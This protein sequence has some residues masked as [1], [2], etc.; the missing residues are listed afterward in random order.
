MSEVNNSVNAQSASSAPEAAPQEAQ[1]QEQNLNAPKTE[2]KAEAAKQEAKKLK[3]VKYKANG[4][5]YSEDLPFEI[6]DNPAAI[7]Y[8]TKQLSLS[9]AAQSAM[10]ES[11]SVKKQVKDF[12]EYLGK[13]TRKAL[14]EMGI[15]VRDLAAAVIEEEIKAAQ[16]TPEQKELE[17]LRSQKKMMEE[18]KQRLREE[19]EAASRSAEEQKAYVEIEKQI[20]DAI[21][22]THL[23][24]EPA[25]VKRV[26][27]Y[28][29]IAN[30]RGIELS[31]KDAMQF[32]EQDVRDEMKS[33]IDKLDDSAF[34]D[35]VGKERLSRQ[36]KKNIAK[37]K[38]VPTTPAT[39]KGSTVEVKKEAKKEEGDKPKKQS[40][41]S[42]FGFK[43]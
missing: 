14:E 31:A 4:K 43:L 8:L 6:D 3:Q 37:A 16:M 26:A 19:A 18:E 33:I 25:T 27:E 23:P 40:A 35:Y 20:T 28:M 22:S 42:Y 41:S 30:L 9:K 1:S 17:E 39:A 11:S 10:Q 38:E 12:V 24:K 7:E 2:A 36:R 34:E 5:E 15:N 13:D 21:S 29:R 32:V